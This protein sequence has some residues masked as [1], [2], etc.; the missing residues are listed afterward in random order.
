M[1]SIIKKYQLTLDDIFKSMD[2]Q[3]KGR[4]SKK[5]IKTFMSIYFHKADDSQVSSV[6]R[7]L[8]GDKDGFISHTDL[9][10][11]LSPYYHETKIPHLRTKSKSA[12]KRAK[13]CKKGHKLSTSKVEAVNDGSG[14]INL[15]SNSQLPGVT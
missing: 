10:Q 14:I 9:Y 6:M 2:T 12:K 11:T 13:S 1:E 7:R 15:R 4:I 8:D 3:S 5:Q